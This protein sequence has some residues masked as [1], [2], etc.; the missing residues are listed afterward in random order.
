MWLMKSL[1]HLVKKLNHKIHR[2]EFLRDVAFY[3]GSA[4]L[5]PVV[6]VCKPSKSEALEIPNKK[7]ADWNP[8]KFNRDRGNAGA[9]PKSYLK[10][11]NGPNG[12]KTHIGKHL[13]YIPKLKK[14]RSVDGFLPIMWGDPSRGYVQHPNAPRDD[15]KNFEGH[16]YD[17]IRIRKSSSKPTAELKSVYSNWPEITESDNGGYLPFEGKD[18]T[19]DSGKNTIYLAALPSDVRKG[20]LIRIYA[21]CKTHGEW[22]DFIEV[23]G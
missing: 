17:W 11:I 9:I 10:D 12:V 18:I 7:P 21:H 22:V 16:W 2:K 23:V 13:P 3:A 4:V 8:V 20:D 15:K 5:V 6:S 1:N 14:A 19:K